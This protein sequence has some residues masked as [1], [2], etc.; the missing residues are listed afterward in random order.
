MSM[1]MRYVVFA[2]ICHVALLFQ[3]SAAVAE[4]EMTQAQKLG[5]PDWRGPFHRSAIA[6]GHELIDDLAQ[7]KLLWKSEDEILCKQYYHVQCSSWAVGACG[8]AGPIYWDGKVYI[9]YAQPPK[10]WP[11]K[12]D[13][14][15]IRACMANP[16]FVDADENVVCMDAMTGKTVWKKVYEKEGF[17]FAWGKAGAHMLQAVRYGNVYTLTTGG[18]AACHDAG[19]G[20]EKWKQELPWRANVLKH[21]DAARKAGKIRTGANRGLCVCPAVADGVVVFQGA[22]DGGG[23]GGPLIGFNAATGEKLWTGKRV[24]IA[25]AGAMQSPFGGMCVSPVVWRVD[26]TELFIIGNKCVEPKTG[27]ILW[28]GPAGSGTGTTA[29]IGEFEGAWYM[30]GRLNEKKPTKGD[31][32]FRITPKGAEKA[33]ELEMPF[34]KRG[35]TTALIHGGHYYFDMQNPDNKNKYSSELV[36]VDMKTGKVTSRVKSLGRHYSS[37]ACADG[38]WIKYSEEGASAT[39]KGGVLMFDTNPS[40]VAI[41]GKH[42][43][44]KHMAG[45]T[46]ILVDGRLYHRGY[47]AVYCYDLRKQ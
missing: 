39:A 28:I 20:D 44:N 10:P 9:Y 29:T 38:R 6:G 33:W 13:R 2:V 16:V 24:K 15:N 42:L 31:Q 11:K 26:G 41:A 21:K 45:T 34:R 32:C 23:S 30:I 47:D 17:N 8:H 43:P 3:G 5:W 25:G 14:N 1:A 7:A 40:A 22:A 27:R 18:Y 12:G 36:C 4:N 46:P 37:P 19:T 35:S